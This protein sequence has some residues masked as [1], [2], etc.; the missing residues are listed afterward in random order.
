MYK[1]G[2][3]NRDVYGSHMTILYGDADRDENGQ[4]ERQSEERDN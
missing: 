2:C 3:M 4:W 1:W